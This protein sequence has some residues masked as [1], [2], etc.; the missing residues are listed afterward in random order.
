MYAQILSPATLDS[1]GVLSLDQLMPIVR[2][3][4]AWGDAQLASLAPR[5]TVAQVQRVCRDSDWSS[6]PVQ[7]QATPE[8]ND[9]IG[10]LRCSL[11]SR[12]RS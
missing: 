8:G 6:G 2:K 11:R 1:N 7:E 4:P 5:L 3:A 9:S 12:R 10:C